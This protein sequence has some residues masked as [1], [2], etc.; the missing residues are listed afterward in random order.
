MRHIDHQ[1]RGGLRLEFLFS[2]DQVVLHQV[3]IIDAVVDVGV[4]QTITEIDLVR[5]IAKLKMTTVSTEFISL[6]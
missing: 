5:G 1:H 4:A 6:T 3:K 2:Y